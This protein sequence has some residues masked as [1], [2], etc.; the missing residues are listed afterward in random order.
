MKTKLI[1]V[2]NECLTVTHI[3]YYLWLHKF[4]SW[5]LCWSFLIK[6][7]C[8]HALMGRECK[9]F[10]SFL[11]IIFF[12]PFL[13]KSQ[14]TT[15]SIL[16]S[17]DVVISSPLDLTVGPFKHCITSTSSPVA[18]GL[19]EL[20]VP[21]SELLLGHK[22]RVLLIYCFRKTGNNVTGISQVEYQTHSGYVQ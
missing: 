17:S 1:Y 8:H 11:F 19:E 7:K 2:H 12:H 9:H 20:S 10:F 21:C 3:A 15:E 18:L 4:L 13:V 16:L 6:A 14:L 5:C 22:V